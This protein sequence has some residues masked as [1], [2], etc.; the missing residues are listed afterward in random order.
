[1]RSFLSAG[2]S[3]EKAVALGC[4][5]SLIAILLHS[6][7]DFNLYIPANALV[8]SLVLGLAMCKPPQ[9]SWPRSQEI[10]S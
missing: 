4:A 3:F 1:M 10:D 2:R 6:L 8:F 9:I 5:G 7:A